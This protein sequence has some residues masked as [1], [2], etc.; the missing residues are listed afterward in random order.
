MSL[1]WPEDS[2][3]VVPSH[4]ATFQNI[5]GD[6][7]VGKIKTSGNIY[8]VLSPN[9]S[10]KVE[11]LG[12]P[13]NPKNN[14]S[15][16]ITRVFPNSIEVSPAFTDVPETISNVQ[17]TMGS[18]WQQFEGEENVGNESLTNTLLVGG[19]NK[20]AYTPYFEDFI[21]TSGLFDATVE[22][23]NIVSFLPISTGGI[24]ASAA[25]T[26]LNDVTHYILKSSD[27]GKVWDTFKKFEEVRGTIQS[28][29]LSTFGHSILTVSYTFPNDFRY[30]DGELDKRN[31]SIFANESFKSVPA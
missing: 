18:W 30:A 25:G 13:S 11:T 24:L 16:L 4:T 6:P 27:L 3:T 19:K 8:E 22:N 15:Y 28:S 20:I 26:D 31:I 17:L 23:V 10:V 29:K 12:D 21:W 5:E 1:R 14:T 9:R 7:S 2:F